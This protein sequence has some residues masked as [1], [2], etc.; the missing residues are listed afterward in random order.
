MPKKTVRSF[1]V[2]WLQI[3]DEEGICDEELRPPVTEQQI[4]KLYQWMVLARTLDEKAFK[5]Q[6]EG[7]LGT[8]ASILGQE[9]AQVGS[10]LALQP[11]DWMFPSFREPGVSIVRGLP[12]RMILQYWSG[13]ER[14]SLIPEELN[15]FPITIPVGTHIPIATGAA[16]A[17]RTKGDPIAVICYFGDGATSK[18]DFH[19]SF[20]FAGVFSLPIVYVCQN[21]HWAISVPLS[22]QTAAETLAQKALAYGFGGIQV[23][24]NDIFAVY[25]A[26][27]EALV[28]AR[29]GQGPTFIEC[30]TYRIGDHTTADDATRYRSQEEVEA[31]KKK[32]PIERLQKYMVK[33]G[34]W[35]IAYAQKIFSEAKEKVEQA[36]K[37][38]EATPAPDP[39]DIFRYTFHE[40][41]D[42][43]REQMEHC[44]S[45][46]GRRGPQHPRS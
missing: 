4:Q 35:D 41:T 14:G 21:D 26:T 11:S 39:R 30:V 36:V 13:D 8:Y 19:E 10:A 40:L 32:D 24:G 12:L 27:D 33:R 38:L 28:R 3:L 44:L 23:D 5:L 31:W 2:E 22:R 42:E 45:G 9:A 17:A 18:G 1:N 7:R 29:A 6:R 25:K 15:D 34:L 46:N 43:L 16:W 20:N 37:E